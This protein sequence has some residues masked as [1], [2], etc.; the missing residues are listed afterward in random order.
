MAHHSLLKTYLTSAIAALA[1]SAGL[2]GLDEGELSAGPDT[3]IRVAIAPVKSASGFLYVGVFKREN[4]LK[5][6]RVT[7]Y[8][9]VPARRGT[10]YVN[11]H[12]LNP[13]RYGVAA[14]HDENSNGKVDFN[15][16]GLP[17]EGYG[18]S[19]T[20]PF[21]KPSFDDTAFDLR[22]RTLQPVRLKY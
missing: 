14:Y 10:V 16:V 20:T 12:G 5:P 21:G 15:F 7:S 11:F 19:K 22:D 17:A 2:C 3:E 1:I 8:Q 6:A 4:W 18:F 13:G 9:K